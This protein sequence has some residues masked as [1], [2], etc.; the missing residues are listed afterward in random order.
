MAGPDSGNSGESIVMV[1]SAH[2]ATGS[3]LVSEIGRT[4]EAA[5]HHSPSRLG[6]PKTTVILA[7]TLVTG[8]IATFDLYLLASTVVH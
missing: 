8:G 6:R 7:L 4:S 5:R 2:A 1:A 3:V